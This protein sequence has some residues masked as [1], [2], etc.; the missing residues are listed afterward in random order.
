MVRI[1]L[2]PC[3]HESGREI[4][5]PP[6]LLLPAGRWVTT[7]MAPTDWGSEGYLNLE[8]SLPSKQGIVL[9]IVLALSRRLVQAVH[10][11]DLY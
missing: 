7:G 8:F 3:T 9:A 5:G 11:P 10:P 2:S 6:S 1:V 4:I